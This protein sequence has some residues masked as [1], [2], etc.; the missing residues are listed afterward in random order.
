VKRSLKKKKKTKKKKKKKAENFS[1]NVA[2]PKKDAT[3]NNA[4]D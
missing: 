3:S 4:L 2:H 1:R